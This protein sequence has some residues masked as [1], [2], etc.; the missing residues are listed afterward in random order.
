M[1]KTGREEYL[2]S[3]APRKR[4]SCGTVSVFFA[5]RNDWAPLLPI[6]CLPFLWLSSYLCSEV[7]E[8]FTSCFSRIYKII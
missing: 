5:A 4:N 2:T 7:F 8:L 3:L 6:T 1:F